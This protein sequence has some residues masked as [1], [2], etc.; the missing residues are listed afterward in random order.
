MLAEQVWHSQL[1][2]PQIAIIGG[3]AIGLVVPVTGIIA[4]YWYKATKLR[5]ENVLRRMLVERGL[6]VQDIER[7]ME[8]GNEP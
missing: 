1:G 8:A 5:S 4:S 7:I 2:I 3:L 6:T